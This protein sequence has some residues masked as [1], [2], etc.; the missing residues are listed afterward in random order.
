MSSLSPL[1]PKPWVSSLGS[2]ATIALESA[3]D[4][5]AQTSEELKGV[6]TQIRS[7]SKTVREIGCSN[8]ALDSTCFSTLT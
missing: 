8:E 7:L 2:A 4:L 5:N 3:T 1:P 6:T